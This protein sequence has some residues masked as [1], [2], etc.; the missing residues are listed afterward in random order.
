MGIPGIDV[1]DYQ[2]LVN[3]S[4]VAA[5]GIKFAFAKATEGLT[6]TATTFARNWTGM[7]AAGMLRGAYHFF[8]PE[9]DPQVQA[10][11]FLKVA[12]LGSEDLPAALDVEVRDRV[13]P[14]TVVTRV[15]QWL[16]TVEGVTGR[17]PILY[18]SPGF[19]DS[20]GTPRGFSDYPLWIAE[21]GRSSPIIPRGWAT[22]TFWQY[23]SGGGVRGTAG[24]TDLN[25]FNGS[26]DDLKLFAAT[27]KAPSGGRLSDDYVYDGDNGSEVEEIQKL[28]QAK[29]FSPGLIDGSFGPRTKAAVVAFQRANNLIID[30]IVGPLT[31][32]RLRA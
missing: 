17:K 30:G 4:A 18:F 32:E 8:R 1:S 23:T 20:L 13:D 14:G 9:T 2:G 28:L 10:N 5:T 11:H 29:G 7:Q 3:W 27:A 26:L 6:F 16:D 24:K 19:W 12:S 22:Y 15:K 21:Y 25:M 31:L